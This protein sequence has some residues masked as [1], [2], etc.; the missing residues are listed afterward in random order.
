MG[1]NVTTPIRLQEIPLAQIDI[2]ETG[3]EDVPGQAQAR[4]A[5]S[6]QEVGLLNPPWLRPQGGGLRFQVVTGTRRLA[7]AA[8]LGWQEIT[9]RVAPED[10]PDFSCLLVHLFDNAFS[11]GFNLKEQAE[12][13]SRLLE[14]CDR[15]TVVSKYLPYLGLPPSGAHLERLIKAAGLEAPWQRLAA[16]GR[17]ALSAAARLADWDPEGRAAAWPFLDGLRLSQSKQEEFLD[18]VVLLARRK[19]LSLSAVL[20][21]DELRRVLTDSDRTPQERTVAVRGHL[22]RWVYPRLSAARE[23]FETALARLGWKGSPRIRL[24]PPAAFEGPDYSLEINFRD[25]PELQGLLADMVRLAGQEEFADLTR[26]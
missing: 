16:Q 21:R 17:L 20:A 4:L 14:Y 10:T 3:L 5:A 7:A 13:A 19:G 22:Y 18:Q 8:Q 11:R 26:L 9:A 23:A 6:L 15:E 24:H 12:L 2:D 1:G 25:A